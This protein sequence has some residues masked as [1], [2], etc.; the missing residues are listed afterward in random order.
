MDKNMLKIVADAAK[1]RMQ[2]TATN[3]VDSEAFVLD[4]RLCMPG[5]K[6]EVIRWHCS[7]GPTEI[8]VDSKELGYKKHCIP[9]CWVMEMG[10]PKDLAMYMPFAPDSW[11][12]ILKKN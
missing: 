11:E 7:N 3:R 12:E 9:F 1:Y 10:A 8:I 6:I 2:F 5:D 4:R